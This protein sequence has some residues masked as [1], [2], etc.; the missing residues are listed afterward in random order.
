MI[1][2]LNLRRNEITNLGVAYLI[3]Y[4][5]ADEALTSLDVSRNKI[6]EEGGQL[7]LDALSKQFR[8]TSFQ[9]SYGN[10]ISLQL[11]LAI[12]QEILANQ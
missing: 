3:D 12:Q 7:F 8:M 11:N 4:L 6:S 1:T 2:T 5:S 9:I 10:P